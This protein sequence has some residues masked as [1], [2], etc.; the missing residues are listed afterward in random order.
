MLEVGGA[1]AGKSRMEWRQ[2]TCAVGCVDTEPAVS[3]E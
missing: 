3:V 2:D 1:I